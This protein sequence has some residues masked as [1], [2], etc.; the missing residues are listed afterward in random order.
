M[1]RKSVVI[2]LVGLLA[3]ASPALADGGT[4][5]KGPGAEWATPMSERELQGIRGGMFEVSFSVFF[6]GFVGDR[7]NVTDTL[8]KDPGGATGLAAPPE[9]SRND[10][11]ATVS[12]VLGGNFNGANGIFQFNL[13]PGD[14]NVVHNNLYLQITMISVQNSS[15][16]PSLSSLL[17]PRR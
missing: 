2:L 1:P 17:Q 4:L 10:R 7:S 16:L 5:G 9:I 15:S 14:F 6:E 13:V 12:A 3:S 11:G 8:T